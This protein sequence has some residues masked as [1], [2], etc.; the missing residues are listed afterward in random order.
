MANFLELCQE[1]AREA[2]ISG[3]IASVTGQAGEHQ[4]V[5]R[6]VARAY[7]Y[8]QNLHE[9]WKFLRRDVEFPVSVDKVNYTAAEARV[10]DF[11]RWCFLDQWRAFRTEAGYV[12]E[13]P[14]CRMDY[15]AFRR[16]YMYSSSREQR[17][18][19]QV[20]TVAPDQSL[21]FW[22]KPDD[23]YTIVGEQYRAPAVLLNNTD[24]P[25]FAAQYHDTIM[26]R[27]LMLYGEFEGDA[28]VIATGQSEFDRELSAM[29][30]FYLPRMSACGAG[31]LA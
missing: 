18:R 11:G 1:M 24:E 5:V 28:T 29:E 22:P 27:A 9:N 3:S 13:Q 30:A 31:A 25:L 15:D 17:G 4:R 26:Y 16:T 7:K 14:V 21:M 10:E 12:D 20:V 8:V 19:P 2:G 23:D 6:W